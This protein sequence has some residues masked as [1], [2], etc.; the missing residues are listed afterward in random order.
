MAGAHILA[1]DQG[2]SSTKCLLVDRQGRVVA[3]GTAE[4]GQRHPHP[5]WVEQ[6]PI[7][8]WQSVAAAVADCLDGQDPA[9]VAAIGFSTQRESL[10]VWD[11][12]SGEPVSPMLGW[13]DQRTA[14]MCAGLR[15]DEIDRQVLERSGLPLDPMFSAIKARWVLDQVPGAEQRAKAGELCLGTVDSWL[16]SRFGGE[17]VIEA[18]NAARTQLLNVRDVAWDD[19]LLDLFGIPAAMLPKVLPSNGPFPSARGLA[20]L[21]DG[22]PV[23][24]VMGDSHSALFAHGAFEPGQV[25]ATYGT[26]SSIMGLIERPDAL[27]EGVCLTIGWM[28]DRPAF[29]AEGNIR[30]T[31]ATIRW[32]AGLLGVSPQELA[33]L[34]AGATSDGVALVPA[35]GGLGAPYWDDKAVALLAGFGL[36]T[37]RDNIARAA[38]ESIPHQ[39][40]DVLDVVDRSVGRVGELFADGGATRNPVLMQLQ[41]DLAGRPVLRSNTAELS[42]LGV[43]HMAGL[44]AGFWNM[45]ELLALPRERQRFEPRMDGNEREGERRHWRRMVARARLRAPD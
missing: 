20:G 21:P 26:G 33:D 5:G 39:V 44:G 35:F 12:R 4:V 45:A 41:A 43:A 18:G 3:S 7:E 32:A 23:L 34:A 16:L 10:V 36:G 24:A 29:A 2:T 15:S 8:I 19:W 25:K 31:G 13:Q 17:H 37:S 28:L 38:L 22:V 27:A 1:I 14:A 11:R 42:A 30:S 9:R 6:D 40:A